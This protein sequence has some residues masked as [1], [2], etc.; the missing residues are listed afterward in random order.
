L[1][2]QRK[3]GSVTTVKQFSTP[4]VAQM[5]GISVGTLERWLASRVLASPKR[6]NIGSRV[7]RLWAPKDVER[8]R[9][10]KQEN[11]RKGRGRK[12]KPKR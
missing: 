3:Y 12:P 4:E 8:V 9:K 1:T 5:A 2:V 7:V 10:Y 6:L 11:Y